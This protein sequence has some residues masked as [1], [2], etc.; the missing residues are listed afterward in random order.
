MDIIYVRHIADVA[1]YLCGTGST[2]A[3][4]ITELLD[5]TTTEFTPKPAP[6]DQP[7]LN[8]EPAGVR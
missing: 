2:Y 3:C 1:A 8:H 5:H 7:S 6:A 4:H